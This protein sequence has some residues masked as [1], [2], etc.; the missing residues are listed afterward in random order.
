MSLLFGFTVVG[1]DLQGG[2]HGV[3]R[4]D[5]GEIQGQPFELGIAEDDEFA[6]HETR[7]GRDADSEGDF[8]FATRLDLPGRQFDHFNARRSFDPVEYERPLAGVLEGQRQLHHI[9]RVE[10]KLAERR[11]AT[12]ALSSP[13]SSET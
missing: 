2:R 13:Q 5:T 9:A 10:K 11:S 1:I 12:A 8:P 3:R 6:L 7:L 4:D